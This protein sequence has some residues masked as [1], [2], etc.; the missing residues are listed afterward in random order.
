MKP[1]FLG[2]KRQ[3]SD[4]APRGAKLCSNYKNQSLT[5]FCEYRNPGSVTQI[6]A[7]SNTGNQY[8]ILKLSTHFENKKCNFLRKTKPTQY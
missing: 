6:S 2:H 7:Q 4:N 3:N 1:L 5:L 8:N